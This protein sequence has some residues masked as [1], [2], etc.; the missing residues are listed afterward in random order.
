[1]SNGGSSWMDRISV[2]RN[3]KHL[4][5]ILPTTNPISRQG[6]PTREKKVS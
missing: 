1:M 5:L 4:V 3:G 6:N 2:W